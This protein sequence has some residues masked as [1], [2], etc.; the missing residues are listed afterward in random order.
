M[1]AYMHLRRK[2]VVAPGS[3]D[4]EIFQALPLGDCWDDA[5]L[6]SVFHYLWTSSST[7]VP[8]TWLEVMT[9]FSMQFRDAVV[10]EPDLVAQY[11]DARQGKF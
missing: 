6:Y 2:P 7:H 11:N 4:R 10:A 3:T 5:E 1:H 8:E 9:E